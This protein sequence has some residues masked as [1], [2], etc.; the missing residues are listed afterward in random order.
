MVPGRLRGAPKGLPEP[1]QGLPEPPQGLPEPSQGFPEPSPHPQLQTPAT[2]PAR[3][4]KAGDPRTGQ[5][6]TWKKNP[7]DPLNNNKPTD[8]QTATNN[9]QSK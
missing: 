2:R 9:Q 8:R 5:E 1:S 7:T 4:R 3:E 6:K